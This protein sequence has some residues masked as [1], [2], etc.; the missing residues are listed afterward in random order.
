VQLPRHVCPFRQTSLYPSGYSAWLAGLEAQVDLRHWAYPAGYQWL[1]KKNPDHRPSTAIVRLLHL[2]LIL[3]GGGARGHH[4]P[5]LA[6][7]CLLRNARR[8][9]KFQP[10]HPRKIGEIE[11][12]G[13]SFIRPTANNLNHLPLYYR[14]PSIERPVLASTG[15]E[16]WASGMENT[17]EVSHELNRDRNDRNHDRCGRFV[18]QDGRYT[19]NEQRK[20]NARQLLRGADL[21][22]APGRRYVA[23]ITQIAADQGGAD[24][25][26]A[27]RS[28][29]IRR[30][31]GMA[32]LAEQIEQKIAKGE[33]IN[34]AEY[35]LLTSTL[36]RVAQR[37]GIDRR[38]LRDVTPSVEAYIEHI[39]A[40]DDDEAVE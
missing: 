16:I 12:Q 30:F 5:R 15:R 14:K 40:H 39:N 20:T 4:P 11:P 6:L 38:N 23:L 21:R 26:S 32:V 24:R 7:Q 9:S 34:V 28:Q 29:L 17:A 37:I 10:N 22:S 2:P 36:V 13:G 35:A 1:T 33:T 8:Q 3:D 18:R 31:S 27:A 25:L 19:A